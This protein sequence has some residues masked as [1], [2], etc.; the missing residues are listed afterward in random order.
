VNNA[1]ASDT[2]EDERDLGDFV[3]KSRM[4]VL[5]LGISIPQCATRGDPGLAG[6]LS[7]A[8]S[9]QVLRPADCKFG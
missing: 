3:P 6:G 2:E 8:F 7:N 1:S 5:E 9:V 4:I